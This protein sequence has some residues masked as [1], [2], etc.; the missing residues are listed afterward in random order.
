M[1][2]LRILRRSMVD[3]MLEQFFV[4]FAILDTVSAAFDL[5]F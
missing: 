2:S 3:K 5:W 4:H 1:K